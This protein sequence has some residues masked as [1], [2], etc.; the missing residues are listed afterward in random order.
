[1][2]SEATSGKRK[3]GAI[4]KQ[5]NSYLRA[6]LI[7]SAHCIFR[8]RA[9]DPLKRW[10]ETLE[11]RRGKKI[12]V[13]R[14]LVGILWAI[15]RDGTAYSSAKLGNASAH[16]LSSHADTLHAQAA[17]MRADASPTGN[18]RSAP[19]AAKR[20]TFSREVAMT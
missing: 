12:A 16:G 20:A 17:Q 3:L 11:Q 5:G 1:M 13:A 6:L 2:P 9:A 10:A 14:R 15:W 4:T 7:Q 8:L 19:R 18:R